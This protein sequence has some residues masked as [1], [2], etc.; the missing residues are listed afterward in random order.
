MAFVDW[1]A[2]LATGIAQVDSEHKVLIE[3]INGLHEAMSKGQGRAAVG[4]VLDELLR[5]TER[6]FSREE[7][8][9]KQAGYTDLASHQRIHAEL[10]AKVRQQRQEFQGGSLL[11][12]DVMA[13]LQ[14]WLVDHIQHVDQRYVPVVKAA[15]VTPC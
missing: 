1:T 7:Q 8:M 13:F 14:K 2:N 4:P 10:V 11:T 12:I 3:L 5:Y 15:G 6:H 9:M